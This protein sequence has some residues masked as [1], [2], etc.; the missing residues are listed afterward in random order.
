MSHL[1]LLSRKMP[2]PSRA[3]SKCLP[4]SQVHSE[5]RK[6][7]GDKAV[8][9]TELQR[10]AKREE[11]G[12][13]TKNVCMMVSCHTVSR[14]TSVCATFVPYSHPFDKGSQ[15]VTS[16]QHSPPQSR[17]QLIQRSLYVLSCMMFEDSSNLKQPAFSPWVQAPECC[18]PS[19]GLN[20]A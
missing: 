12:T 6:D 1:E 10:G 4:L 13:T 2:E 19:E 15:G 17:A 11:R 7:R 3:G 14:V 8:Q 18:G 16:D 9:R 20:T 5:R